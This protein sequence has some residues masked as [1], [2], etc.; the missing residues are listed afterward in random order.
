M[1]F[2]IYDFEVFK[3]D[4][5]F[6]G[7]ELDEKGNQTL[8]QTWDLEEIKDLYYRT[9]TEWTIFIGWNNYF[10][11]NYIMEAIVNGKDP[12]KVSK[13]VIS[14]EAKRKK[15]RF[16]ILSYDLMNT[17][18]M[19][20]SLK[21][22]ELIAGKNIHTT[23]VDFDLDRCLS[24]EE[25]RKTEEYN[26]SDLNQT[27][28]NFTMFFNK[29]V[30]RIDLANEFKIPL[31]QAFMSTDAQLAAKVL[32]A[33]HIDGIENE[34][35]SPPIYPNLKLENKELWDFYL[36]EGF[37][38]NLRS[39]KGEKKVI[40]IG[41]AQVTYGSGGTHSAISK[42]QCDKALYI[43]VSGFYNRIMIY[44][45]LLPR[46]LS[47]EGKK[48]YAHMF[49]QQLIMKKTNPTKRAA[50]KIVLL[51]V[52]GAEML[53]FSD[54]YDPQRGSLVTITGQLFITD[55]MEKLKDLVTIVQ[56]N[57]DGAIVLP[58]NWDDESKILEIIKEW[59]DRTNFS[60]KKIHIYDVWQRDVNNYIYRDEDGKIEFR[61]E[62]VKNYDIG[63]K[64]YAGLEI[65]NCTNPPIV[66]R[67][68]V[69]YLIKGI[70]PEETVE[71]E[72]NNLRMFQY[73]CKKNTFDY[74]TYDLY[75]IINNKTTSQKLSGNDRAFAYKNKDFVGMVYKHKDKD[76]KH[77][78][79]KVANLPDNVFIYNDEILSEEAVNNIKDK[80]N[81]EFYI[82][83]IYERIGEFIENE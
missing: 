37:R 15:C 38:E 33:K 46:T 59:E 20:L 66:A 21:T 53:K 70:T 75:D 6:G 5:L 64:A 8:I 19:F 56:L 54:L 36:R 69:D 31:K 10:Y 13:Y 65:F 39:G 4:T 3:Y 32:G 17:T 23:E 42:F 47:E 35:I 34:L 52:F 43:D 44:Y 82:N 76:N 79:A 24:D 2:I 45:D 26:K 30:L 57:T 73:I 29:L 83:R 81:Y 61:G 72:K 40:Q 67:G 74:T 60:C 22:T 41:N 68:I 9:K 51:A 77:M 78:K 16:D 7:I 1:K 14:T 49:E 11:D 25:K 12:Y 18:N 50:Y 80:I 63:P 58:N 28:Y 71:K 27:L 55:L 62:I 48:K